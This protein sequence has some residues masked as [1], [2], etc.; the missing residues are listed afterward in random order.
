MIS[1]KNKAASRGMGVLLPIVMALLI[2]L[3]LGASLLLFST[4]SSFEQAARDAGGAIAEQIAQSA[5]EEALYHFQK[6]VNDP[7]SPLFTKVRKALILGDRPSLDLSEECSPSL[8]V[9]DLRLSKHSSFYKHIEIENLSLVMRIPSSKGVSSLDG[10]LVGEGEQFI[11]LDSSVTL[12]LSHAKL[13]RR[14]C[15]RR[16]FGVTFISNYKPFDQ[17]TFAILRS[18]FLS[19]YPDVLDEMLKIMDNVKGVELFLSQFSAMLSGPMERVVLNPVFVPVGKAPSIKGEA[20]GELKRVME[21][22]RRRDPSF[23]SSLADMSEEQEGWFKW[24]LIAGRPG[25][26]IDREKPDEYLRLNPL[27]P[28]MD[29][30]SLNRDIPPSDAIIFS[31]AA[32]VDLE[33]FDYDKILL[34]DFAPRL[35]EIKEAAQL[36]NDSVA[37]MVGQSSRELSRQEVE[38]LHSSSEQAGRKLEREIKKAIEVLNSISEHLNG[39]TRVGFKSQALKGYLDDSS[40]RL[41]NLAYHAET[42]DDIEKLG[43]GLAAFNGHV[44]YNGKEPLSLSLRSWAGKTIISAPYSNAELAP[45]TLSSLTRRD[46]SRDFLV[47]NHAN[48]HLRTGKIEASIFAADRLFFEGLPEIEGNLIINNLRLREN[49][50]IDEDLQGTVSYDE[51]CHSG[52]FLSK[53]RSDDGY[54]ERAIDWDRV[55]FGHYTV[56]LCPRGEDRVI[57]RSRNAKGQAFEVEDRGDD[58]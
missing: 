47:V 1:M 32:K 26:L 19:A 41:R 12:Q 14:V 53:P 23:D 4:G 8:L 27:W 28:R 54:V 56:G 55:S 17:L 10:D 44:N 39:H 20:R 43:K 48:L 5:I 22:R 3:L 50:S 13:W 25:A 37:A 16:R 24:S 7:E 58:E 21:E 2:I 30:A 11:D 42:L 46:S 33:D 52:E 51:L 29:R 45:L 15:V 40:K 6:K 34:D 38:R 9:K 49:R 57:F 18:G 36:Y 31:I 35:E